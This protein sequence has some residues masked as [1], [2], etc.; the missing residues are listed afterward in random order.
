MTFEDTDFRQE[1][2]D[3]ENPYDVKLV[4]EFLKPLGLTFDSADVEFT[5]IV[6]NLKGDIIGTGSHMCRTLK[7]VAVNPKYRD[8]TAFSLIVTSLTE[9]LLAIYKNTYVF[10]RPENAVYFKGLGYKLIATSE[11]LFCMLEFGFETIETY[12]NYLK[13]IKTENQC[14][15][16]ASIVVNCNPFTL[17]HQY[18]IERAAEENDFLYLFVVEEN[19]SVFPFDIRWK[20]IEKG[21]SHLKNVLM[22]KGGD[23]IVSGCIFPAYFLKNELDSDILHKQAELDISIFA[24]YIVPILG[25]NK[26]YVGTENYCKTTKAYNEAMY[27]I[28]PGYGVDVI[29]I[30]R[31]SIDD[32]YISASLVRNHIKNNQLENILN[33]LPLST[34]EFLLSNESNEIKE[35]IK[36]SEGRH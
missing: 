28:L 24:Q 29:E 35:K 2:L 18:L 31:K 10:T 25:I 30:T 36:K 9:K 7:Y 15:N 8:T 13:T 11:P 22:V 19:K 32:E 14:H 34:K 33:F 17:G 26:R 5:L 21:I 1:V 23:Y 12:Q 6:Y 3:L 4:T 20:L 16:I 27:K